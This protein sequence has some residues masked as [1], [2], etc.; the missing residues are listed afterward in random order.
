MMVAMQPGPHTAN[1]SDLAAGIG[2]PGHRG[3]FRLDGWLGHAWFARPSEA[4]Q[5]RA[6][7]KQTLPALRRA[8][9]ILSGKG[10]AVARRATRIPADA[11]VGIGAKASPLR[12][13]EDRKAKASVANDNQRRLSPKV[14]TFLREMLFLLLFGATLAGTYYVGRLHAFQ[15]VIVVPD[16]AIKGGRIV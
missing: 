16:T 7:A 12:R 3:L 1:G 11:I 14:R 6:E 4:P 2:V 8:E 15:N 10:R 9:L 5:P 13:A